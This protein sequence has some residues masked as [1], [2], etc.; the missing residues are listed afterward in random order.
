M[1]DY[2][3]GS[4]LADVVEGE[5]AGLDDEAERKRRAKLER[6]ERNVRLAFKSAFNPHNVTVIIASS[7]I[8]YLALAWLFI[9]P[10][11]EAFWPW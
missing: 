4:E 5:A 10:M 7:V 8:F 9:S 11:I 6:R 2:Q 3:D 1:N